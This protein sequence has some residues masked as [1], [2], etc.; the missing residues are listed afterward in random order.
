MDEL[1]PLGTG[2]ATDRFMTAPLPKPGPGSEGTA[3]AEVA[4]LQGCG[5]LSKS[6]G[7]VPPI[8]LIPQPA[9]AVGGIQLQTCIHRVEGVWW[10]QGAPTACC[11]L[12]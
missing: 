10:Q 7:D 9:S 12:T 4:S 11:Q 2:V 8:S 5:S 1:A 3:T 6:I